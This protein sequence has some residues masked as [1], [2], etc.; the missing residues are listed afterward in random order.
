MYLSTL[1]SPCHLKLGTVIEKKYLS[2]YYSSARYVVVNTYKRTRKH[3]TCLS[4]YLGVIN[5]LLNDRVTTPLEAGDH[6]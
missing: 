1:K 2:I 4:T 5:V 6:N 3:V